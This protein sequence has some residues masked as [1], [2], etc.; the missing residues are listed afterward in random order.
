MCGENPPEG[1]TRGFENPVPK[2]MAMYPNETN[3]RLNTVVFQVYHPDRGL[4]NV[5]CPDFA[6]VAQLCLPQEFKGNHLQD[7][8]LDENPCN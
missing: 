4:S 6:K 1:E 2:F 8:D 7:F 3:R 5:T